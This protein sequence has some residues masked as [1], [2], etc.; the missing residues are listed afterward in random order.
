[1]LQQLEVAK[2]ELR[3]TLK[4]IKVIA[5]QLNDTQ[6]IEVEIEGLLESGKTSNSKQ[7]LTKMLE[8]SYNL[9]KEEKDLKIEHEN[10]S[11]ALCEEIKKKK[12][13]MEDKLKVE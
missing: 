2:E 6:Y 7:A 3:K 4:R 9:V 1:M 11:A 10:Q 5:I 12:K 8:K 13:E